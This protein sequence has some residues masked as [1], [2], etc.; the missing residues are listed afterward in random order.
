MYRNLLAALIVM[1]VSGVVLDAQA[2]AFQQSTHNANTAMD[3]RINVTLDHAPL[4]VAL[5][6]IAR[7][8]GIRVT[9]GEDVFNSTK[10]VTLQTKGVPAGVVF[11]NALRGTGI[12]MSA[13]KSGQ[14]VF[15]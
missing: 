10:R 4:D 3:A 8:A 13:V 5:K 2:V 9:L 6:T 11:R 12:T 14:V 15:E 7:E 1:C